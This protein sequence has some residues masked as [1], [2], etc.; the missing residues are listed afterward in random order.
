MNKWT[1]DSEDVINLERLSGQE[2]ALDVSS[3]KTIAAKIR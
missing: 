2:N 3:G 1:N